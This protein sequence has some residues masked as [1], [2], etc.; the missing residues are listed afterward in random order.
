MSVLKDF[1]QELRKHPHEGRYLLSGFQD[2]I[3]DI[4]YFNKAS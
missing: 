2:M 1:V 4:F 3:N